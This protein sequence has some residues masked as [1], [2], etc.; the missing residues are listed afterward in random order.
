MPSLCNIATDKGTVNFLDRGIGAYA[1][2]NTDAGLPQACYQ[3]GRPVPFFGGFVIEK[4]NLFA[5]AVKWTVIN[6]DF[7]Y[8]WGSEEGYC[9]VNDPWADPTTMWTG[10]KDRW[11]WT[12]AADDV[13]FKLWSTEKKTDYDP[14]PAGYSITDAADWAKVVKEL[15]YT[16]GDLFAS[17]EYDGT[18][19]Y[20]PSTLGRAYDNGEYMRTNYQD[21]A[22][23]NAW[24]GSVFLDTFYYD[25]GLADAP[26]Y[27]CCRIN[28]VFSNEAFRY[29]EGLAAGGF[30]L[31]VF[32]KKL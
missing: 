12:D 2:G 19:F 31:P 4:D 15:T 20:I 1:L 6:P 13:F 3:F 22:A 9:D 10:T 29:N 11:A 8:K 23:I 25:L 27:S 17:Y 28:V 30:A 5:D 32:L 21:Q 16:E 18:I 7:D 26:T 24:N 14:A